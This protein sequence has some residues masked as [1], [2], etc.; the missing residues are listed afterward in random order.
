ME[1]KSF[2]AVY[3]F[4]YIIDYDL[5]DLNS[6]PDIIAVTADLLNYKYCVDRVSVAYIS[7]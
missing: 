6:T 4:N 7:F 5:V 2:V 3:C 1:G